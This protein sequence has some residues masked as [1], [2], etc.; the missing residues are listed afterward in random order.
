GFPDSVPSQWC[1]K[2]GICS[3]LST[4]R[5]HSRLLAEDGNTTGFALN[6]FRTMGLS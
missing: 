6:G 5:M 2:S 4:H 1:L 3:S